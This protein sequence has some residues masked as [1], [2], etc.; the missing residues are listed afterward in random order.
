MC[1][2]AKLK[3]FSYDFNN[4]WIMQ[5]SFSL[6]KQNCTDDGIVKYV[7]EFVKAL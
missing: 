7:N 6:L 2:E 1:L 3:V 4:Q 5:V